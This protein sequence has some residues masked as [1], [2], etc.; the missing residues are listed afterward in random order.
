MESAHWCPFEPAPMHEA[1]SNAEVATPRHKFLGLAAGA[2]A[3]P[4]VSRAAWV[5]GYPSRPVRIIDGFPPGDVSDISA[6]LTGQC[7][8]SDLASHS[9]SRTGRLPRA[10]S[11]PRLS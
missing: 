1:G 9:S 3:L 2:A 6:R 7:C 8:R 4:A 10:I 5:Q 11:P